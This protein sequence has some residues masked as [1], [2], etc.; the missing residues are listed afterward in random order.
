MSGEAAQIQ[1]RDATH[2]KEQESQRTIVGAKADILW[3][4]GENIVVLNLLKNTHI[5]NWSLNHQ[6]KYNELPFA[7]HAQTPYLENT[8]LA[9]VTIR[10]SI[11]YYFSS[12]KS[13]E[14]PSYIPMTLIG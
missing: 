7:S 5:K 12:I 14:D 8:T 11:L 3:K 6:H 4:W 1:Q 13:D 2:N 10:A 9:I